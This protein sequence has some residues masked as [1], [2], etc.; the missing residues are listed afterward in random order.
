MIYDEETDGLWPY[1]VW[2]DKC[3][4]ECRPGGMAIEPEID[5]FLEAQGIAE[6]LWAAARGIGD[7]DEGFT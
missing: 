2:I 6:A 1:L 3:L 4:A 5:R 7:L